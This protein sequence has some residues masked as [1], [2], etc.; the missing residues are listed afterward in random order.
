MIDIAKYT[1]KVNSG[2]DRQKQG[3]A[4]LIAPKLAISA[5]HVLSSSSTKNVYFTHDDKEIKSWVTHRGKGLDVML[6][7]LEEEIFPDETV[8]PELNVEF[9]PKGNDYKWKAYGFPDGYQRDLKGENLRQN[10]VGYKWD[11]D[12]SLDFTLKKYDGISGAPVLVDDQVIGIIIADVKNHQLGVLSLRKINSSLNLDLNPENTK[13]TAELSGPKPKATDKFWKKFI[14]QCNINKYN[15][16]DIKGLEEYITQN[17]KGKHLK[18]VKTQLTE[19]SAWLEALDQEDFKSFSKKY[20]DSIFTIEDYEN[21]HYYL[22]L[23]NI[24][25]H[26]DT[27]I[28]PFPFENRLFRDRT[29]EV[30]QT[31]MSIHDQFKESI[32]PDSDGHLTIDPPDKNMIET[33]L[34]TGHTGFRWVAQIEPIWNAYYL[35]LVLRV[36]KEMEQRRAEKSFSKHTHSYRFHPDYSEG[37]LFRKRLGFQFSDRTEKYLKEHG[38]Q[39][40]DADLDQFRYRIF[41]DKEDEF[42]DKLRAAINAGEEQLDDLCSLSKINIS[43]WFEFQVSSY[44]RVKNDKTITHVVSCDIADFYNR[45]NHSHL[46]DTLNR[47]EEIKE[48][49]LE[50]I[51]TYS[52]DKS[53]GIPIGGNASRILAENVLFEFDE[54]LND[55]DIKFSRFV[56]DYYFFSNDENNANK[57][58]NKFYTYLLNDQGLSLQK[59]K[60]QIYSRTEFLHSIETRLFWR[61]EDKNVE[62]KARVMALARFDYYD[63]MNNSTNLEGK[64]HLIEIERLLNEELR[65][66]RIHEQL[67]TRLLQELSKNY[68]KGVSVEEFNIA[69][70]EA[71]ITIF[72]KRKDRTE[73]DKILKLYPIF[74]K[75]LLA[76]KRNI[77]NQRFQHISIKV[78][79]GN[80]SKEVKVDVL[81]LILERLLSLYKNESYIYDIELYKSYLFY[82]LAKLPSSYHSKLYD[83]ENGAKLNLKEFFKQELKEEQAIFNSSWLLINLLICNETGHF[84]REYR[85]YDKMDY[86]EKR[87]FIIGAILIDDIDESKIDQNKLNDFERIIYKWAMALGN[88]ENFKEIL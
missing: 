13:D 2:R 33:P 30:I 57:Q 19:S 76:I 45:I 49:L 5:K 27:D 41:E 36:A 3:T 87:I 83:I 25:T 70:S 11:I 69:I 12:L 54:F 85:K 29:E 84:K 35:S 44:E 65:K 62:D 28:F 52:Q 10:T 18:D 81:N 15:Y 72:N 88:I 7:E 78:K 22:A 42:K 66:S 37:Y 64:K 56:D 80:S 74:R 77:Q 67:A 9:Q 50:L 43:D 39:I 75:L 14:A 55:N 8:F 79:A 17:P 82:L 4:F 48:V 53:H 32:D 46:S 73:K 60:I 24:W 47:Y 63:E 23:K 34:P 6:L 21:R 61:S 58:L 1:F 68:K 71:F 16:L 59:H 26:G 86:W 40:K 31:L 51:K 20:P 38:I